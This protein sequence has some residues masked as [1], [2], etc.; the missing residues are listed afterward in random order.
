MKSL[1]DTYSLGGKQSLN[2]AVNVIELFG[3]QIVKT[4]FELFG[5]VQ[6]GIKCREAHEFITTSSLII[7]G[8]WCPKCPKIE[9][10]V[11]PNI[12]IVNP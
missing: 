8:T 10:K 1:Y 3:G 7:N 2:R 12:I 11:D 4:S 9:K 6:I 5:S